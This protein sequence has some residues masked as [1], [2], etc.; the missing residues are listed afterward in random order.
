MHYLNGL[1]LLNNIILFLCVASV[2]SYSHFLLLKILQEDTVIFY[3]NDALF[4][5]SVACGETSP[6]Q[7]V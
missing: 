3:Q 6:L 5:G 7:E 1:I 2:I 4:R